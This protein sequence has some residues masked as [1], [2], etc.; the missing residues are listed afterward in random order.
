M[1]ESA[2]SVRYRRFRYQAQSDIADHGYRTKCPP[3][4][5]TSVKTNVFVMHGETSFGFRIGFF[6]LLATTDVLFFRQ[7]LAL[8]CLK[9]NGTVVRVFAK[10]KKESFPVNAT[11]HVV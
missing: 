4:P 3:M 1:S 2:L 7:N 10:N 9:P 5:A 8:I 6:T 11:G